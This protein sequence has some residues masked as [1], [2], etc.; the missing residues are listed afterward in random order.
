M[1]NRLFATD[2]Y[3]D[4]KNAS[5]SKSAVKY[6]SRNEVKFKDE[7]ANEGLSYDEIQDEVKNVWLE[8]LKV[9]DKF[10]YSDYTVEV[11]KSYY[12]TK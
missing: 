2:S 7:L 8:L 10:K 12:N 5:E 11:K 6:L 9:C 1:V 4:I 3:E